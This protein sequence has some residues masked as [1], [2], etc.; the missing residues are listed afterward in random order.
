MAA[1]SHELPSKTETTG[2]YFYQN[3]IDHSSNNSVS[4][5]EL[6]SVGSMPSSSASNDFTQL[7]QPQSDTHI[8]NLSPIVFVDPSV[9]LLQSNDSHQSASIIPPGTRHIIKQHGMGIF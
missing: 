7:L 3:I 6:I 4:R 2:E 5:N 8:Q 1:N 9:L